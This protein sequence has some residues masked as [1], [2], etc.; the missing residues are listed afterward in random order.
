MA[1]AEP[2]PERQ[3]LIAASVGTNLG[4]DVLPGALPFAL[5]LSGEGTPGTALLGAR[6][7]NTLLIALAILF[8]LVAVYLLVCFRLA[9]FRA[10]DEP[11]TTERIEQVRSL[12]RDRRRGLRVISS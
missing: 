2:A 3:E 9:G 8:A 12:A 4:M 6:V 10:F 1:A 11:I 5:E 7:Q